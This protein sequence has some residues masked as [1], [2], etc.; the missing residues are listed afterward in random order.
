MAD[1]AFVMLNLQRWM[2]KEAFLCIVL[3]FYEFLTNVLINKR[4]IIINSSSVFFQKRKDVFNIDSL[5]V[6]L[7]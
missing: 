2:N 1:S 5:S 3:S 6:S 7:V 4:C